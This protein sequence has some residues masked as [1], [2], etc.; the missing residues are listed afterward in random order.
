M[1]EMH[2]TFVGPVAT[3]D[4]AHGN[5]WEP[6]HP[7]VS[8]DTYE[9]VFCTQI[10]VGAATLPLPWGQQPVVLRGSRHCMVRKWS[11]GGPRW[12]ATAVLK[13]YI[14]MKRITCVDRVRWYEYV[15]GPLCELF[16]RRNERGGCRPMSYGQNKTL[17]DICGLVDEF[18]VLIDGRVVSC[19]DRAR[20]SMLRMLDRAMRAVEAAA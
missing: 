4:H 5:W 11:S 14:R 1:A 2:E 8:R 16:Y 13:R 18:S 10:V 9:H 20:R 6:W 3:F 12:Y 17:S 7:F 19:H 15:H